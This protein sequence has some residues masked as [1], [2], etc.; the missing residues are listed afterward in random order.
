M[1]LFRRHAVHAGS[2]TD[3]LSAAGVREG[4]GTGSSVLVV[5][6][7]RV[8]VQR[9]EVGFFGFHVEMEMLDAD[10]CEIS[11]LRKQD[12]IDTGQG[13]SRRW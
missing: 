9:T 10:D 5:A 13:S 4:H 11:N 2:V 12:E 8:G 3:D 6:V 1:A 7:E